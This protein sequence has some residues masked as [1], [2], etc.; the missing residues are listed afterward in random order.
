M[1]PLLISLSVASGDHS[2]TRYCRELVPPTAVMHNDSWQSPELEMPEWEGTRWFRALPC[3]EPPP[4]LYVRVMTE[5]AAYERQRR[6]RRTAQRIA[7]IT[8][9]ALLGLMLVIHI[10]RRFNR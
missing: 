3:P 6:G 2:P 4:W 7:G 10:E 1:R 8:A 5:I 9:I